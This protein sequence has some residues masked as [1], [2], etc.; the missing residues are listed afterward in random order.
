[1]N[2]QVEDVLMCRGMVEG[3]LPGGLPAQQGQGRQVCEARKPQERQEASAC[4]QSPWLRQH[5]A[6]DKVSRNG[7]CPISAQTLKAMRFQGRHRG[8]GNLELRLAAIE[9]LDEFGSGWEIEDRQSW[10]L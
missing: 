1:M 3:N 6:G 8:L 7:E 9:D 2:G 10:R 4:V 5:R